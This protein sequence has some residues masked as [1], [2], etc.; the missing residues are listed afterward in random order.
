VTTLNL[1]VV[2]LDIER[3]LI[4]V[5]ARPRNAGGWIYVRDAVKK[6]LPKE[7]PKPGKYRMADAASGGVAGKRRGQRVKIDITSSTARPPVRLTSTMRFLAS[8]RARI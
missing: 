1:R 8:F 3:G 6:A 2:E 4:L 5:E 7:A